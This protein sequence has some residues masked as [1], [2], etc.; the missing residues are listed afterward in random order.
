MSKHLNISTIIDKNKISS[1]NAFIILLAVEVKNPVDGS[2][3]ETIRFCKNSENI[4]YKGDLY[5]ATNFDID[6]KV[7]MNKEPQITLKARDQTRALGQY[8]DL[9]DG[10]M[11]NKVTMYIVN[12]ASLTEAEIEEEFVILSASIE[13]YDCEIALGVESAVNQRFPNYRQ[14]KDRCVWKYKGQRCKYTGP[15][16]TCDYTRTGSNGCIAHD[17]EINFGGFPGIN[18]LF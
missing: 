13:N 16:P 5:I 18:D 8:I 14:F 15:L 3:V 2:I 11:N 7:E 17:N 1:D 4:T 9:Y 6:V 12:S 10:L